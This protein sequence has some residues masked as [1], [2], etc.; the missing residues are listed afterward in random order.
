MRWASCTARRPLRSRPTNKPNKQTNKQ[1]NERTLRPQLQSSLRPAVSTA[2]PGPAT[3]KRRWLQIRVW[4]PV[5]S[6]AQLWLYANK[7][8]RVDQM[9]MVPDLRELWLQV[10]ER[11]LAHAYTRVL[12]HACARAIVCAALRA[13][14]RT[15]AS[16]RLLRSTTCPRSGRSRS[17]CE[18]LR[19]PTAAMGWLQR[20]LAAGG[21]CTDCVIC[22]GCNGRA[23]VVIF[24]MM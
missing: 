23:L 5:P 2:R 9:A 10:S 24:I 8:A 6:S 18:P 17:R 13:P 14:L 15:I 20:L 19:A 4:L 3:G 7:I 21:A 1:T 16:S 12:A 22:T 11:A